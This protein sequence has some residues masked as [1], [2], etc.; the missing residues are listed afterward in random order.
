MQVK[1]CPQCRQATDLQAPRCGRCGHLY[2]TLVICGDRT[3]LPP[4]SGPASRRRPSWLRCLGGWAL[5]TAASILL[6]VALNNPTPAEFAYPPPPVVE[7]AP[8]VRAQAP[9]ERWELE[10]RLRDGEIGQRRD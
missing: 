4:Q 10:R 3:L 9:G 2:R 1:V 7:D 6:L 8:P 5:G